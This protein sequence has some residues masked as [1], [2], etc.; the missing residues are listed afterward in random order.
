[1]FGVTRS[2]KEIAF[3][4][5]ES[6]RDVLAAAENFAIIKNYAVTFGQSFNS[7]SADATHSFS[8]TDFRRRPEGEDLQHRKGKIAPVQDHGKDGSLEG[9]YCS[10]DKRRC[11]E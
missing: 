2:D 5:G 6:E 3:A 9:R 10:I 1:L 7:S 4:G 8:R 11:C